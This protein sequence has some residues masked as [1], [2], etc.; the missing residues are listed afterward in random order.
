[1]G[2]AKQKAEV[3]VEPLTVTVQTA[4]RLTGVSRDLLYREM[5]AERLATTKVRGRRL[6]VYKSLMQLVAPEAAEAAP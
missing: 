5:K 2:H 3:A 4:V 6:V 1:M